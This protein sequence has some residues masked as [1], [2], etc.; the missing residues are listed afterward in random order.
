LT[1]PRGFTLVEVLVAIAVLGLSAVASIH[2]VA[3]AM[4][5]AQGARDAEELAR[6]AEALLGQ[7]RV[8]GFPDG[9][10]ADGDFEDRPDIRWRVEFAPARVAGARGVE[11][12]SI[13]LSAGRT[14]RAF[15]ALV[16]RREET[17]A[18]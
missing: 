11:T 13:R 18:P 6:R 12:A 1:R 2:A 8:D 15:V 4:R 16:R 10:T 9:P 5:T 14:E 3:A 17:P 7:W